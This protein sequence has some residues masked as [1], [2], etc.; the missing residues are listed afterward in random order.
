MNEHNGAQQGIPVHRQNHVA[1]MLE[2][3]RRVS[4]W[5]SK[6]YEREHVQELAYKLLTEEFTE[7]QE[8]LHPVHKLDG[9]CDT[10]FVALGVLWKLDVEG[11]FDLAH[12]IHSAFTLADNFHSMKGSAYVRP[13]VIGMIEHILRHDSYAAQFCL[14]I[15]VLCAYLACEELPIDADTFFEAC[16]IVADS[17]DTKA[18]KRTASHVKANIDK[19]TSFVPPEQRLAALLNIDL[20]KEK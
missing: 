8:A 4:N 20:P 13:L 12:G 11:D 15:T 5:N 16:H 3:Y 10:A 19:G 17:N 2:F 14:D 1:K 6:R 7:Y 18:V 9:L